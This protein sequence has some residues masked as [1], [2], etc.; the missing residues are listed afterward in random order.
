MPLS[1]THDAEDV[2]SKSSGTRPVL[3]IGEQP[4]QLVKETRQRGADGIVISIIIAL[5]GRKT[6]QMGCERWLACRKRMPQSKKLWQQRFYH[7]T[8]SSSEVA[9]SFCGSLATACASSFQHAFIG[10]SA[11]LQWADVRLTSTPGTAMAASGLFSSL[12]SLFPWWYT[13]FCMLRSDF[14]LAYS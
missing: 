11:V 2:N 4:V 10:N 13:H 1:V 12:E 5:W 7:L 14:L 3:N 8:L 6:V 9:V